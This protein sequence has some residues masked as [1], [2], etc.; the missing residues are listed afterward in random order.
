[1]CAKP[2]STTPSPL[3]NCCAIAVRISTDCKHREH[4]AQRI[5]TG[6]C[7][8]CTTRKDTARCVC[9]RSMQQVNATVDLQTGV[10]SD[11]RRPSPYLNINYIY[12]TCTDIVRR[13]RQRVVVVVVCRESRDRETRTYLS[14]VAVLII[15]IRGTCQH[16]LA[17]ST[18]VYWCNIY[19][20]VCSAYR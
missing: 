6:V 10:T 20:C 14:A 17:N 4:A 8:R 12:N 2:H 13:R 5:A 19:V 18:L 9:A 11:A 3:R 1:M 7:V 16:I 15:T